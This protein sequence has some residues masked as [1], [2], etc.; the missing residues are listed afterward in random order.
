MTTSHVETE[1]GALRPVPAKWCTA[2]P[3]ALG[4]ATV[5]GDKKVFSTTRRGSLKENGHDKTVTV[6]KRCVFG[7]TCVRAPLSAPPFP[8]AT[9]D[10]LEPK[11]VVKRSFF[12]RISDCFG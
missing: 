3:R 12:F 11:R 4:G 1:G 7:G 6:P 5:R 8:D 9:S 10:P 2:T